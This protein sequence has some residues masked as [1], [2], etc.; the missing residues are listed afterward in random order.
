MTKD[1]TT[2]EPNAYCV[3]TEDS[4]K[5][6]PRTFVEVVCS[7]AWETPPANEIQTAQ[8]SKISFSIFV[9]TKRGQFLV[10]DT[11]R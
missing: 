3:E 11:W 6:H 1:T 8:T 7:V 2:L 9:I 4:D 10:L 5:C